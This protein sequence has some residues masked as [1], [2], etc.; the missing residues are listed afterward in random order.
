MD[1]GAYC[2]I[3][4]LEQEKAIPVGKKGPGRFP[5]GFYCYVGSA[6]NGLERR[7]SRH[8]SRDKKRFWHIDWLLEHASLQGVE[9]AESDRRIECDISRDMARISD[10]EVKGFGCSDCRCSS[11]LYYFRDDPSE[12]VREVVASWKRS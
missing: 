7:I 1:S 6:M 8:A 5:A 9:R 10:S 2:L 11:H 12:R 4:R 3:M